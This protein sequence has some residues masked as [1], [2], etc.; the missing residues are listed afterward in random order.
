VGLTRA[1][2]C[3]TSDTRRTSC[4]L[5]P[6]NQQLV[7]GKQ[8]ER[9]DRP[10]EP[11]PQVQPPR[12][13]FRRVHLEPDSGRTASPL[14]GHLDLPPTG[15]GYVED[16]RAKEFVGGRFT[17]GR[18]KA[19]LTGAAS[20]RRPDADPYLRFR[21]PC[22]GILHQDTDVRP[23]ARASGPGSLRRRPHQLGGRRGGRVR[24]HCCRGRP[25]SVGEV[26]SRGESRCRCGRRPKGSDGHGCGSR[27]S[28]SGR[29]G[30]GNGEAKNG[31]R[32]RQLRCD[33]VRSGTRDKRALQWRLK[34]VC[35]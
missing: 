20:R 8:G 17:R 5:L 28:R 23:V 12:C 15:F 32:R 11:R 22:S 31:I 10:A 2:R 4:A 30:G 35:F 18:M 3:S 24:A 33:R 27:K 6:Q 34:D 29:A 7:D 21:L 14:E 25:C 13:G 16:G 19:G 9:E 26:V 1:R